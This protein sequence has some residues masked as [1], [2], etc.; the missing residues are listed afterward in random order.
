MHIHAVA[1]EIN[2][3][4]FSISAS[5]ITSKFVGEAERTMRHLF[6]MARERAPAIIFIDEIDSLLTARGGSNEGEASRRVKTEFLV[7]FDGVLGSKDAEASITVIGAT[8]LPDQLDEAVLRR[9]PKRIM[10]PNPDRP[11]RYALLRLMTKKHDHALTEENFQYLADATENYSGS[12]L[13]MLCSDALMGPLREAMVN[14]DLTKASKSEIPRLSFRHFQ[15]SLNNVRASVP[16]Q[17]LRHYFDW[18]KQFGSSLFLTVDV[19]PDTMRSPLLISIEEERK[20]F[21]QEHATPTPTPTTTTTTTASNSDKAATTAAGATRSDEQ[22]TPE[23]DVI[24]TSS[25][26]LGSDDKDDEEPPTIGHSKTRS[27]V[28]LP[29]KAIKRNSAA[30]AR[31][32]TSKKT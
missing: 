5:S 17:S 2:C 23:S 7:Q 9:F 25:L 30:S 11:A 13:T 31:I 19:L 26:G 15:Q 28:T 4:F 12:D 16:P 8:N 10:V 6:R 32:T 29:V 18:D 3:T 21:Y 14:T 24:P 1:S 22:P 27:A 20:I